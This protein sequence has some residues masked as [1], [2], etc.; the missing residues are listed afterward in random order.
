MAPFEAFDHV[1]CLTEQ[2]LV[3]DPALPNG[4]ATGYLVVPYTRD[5]CDAQR[6]ARGTNAVIA[7]DPVNPL[8][9]ANTAVLWEGLPPG[10]VAFPIGSG[11]VTHTGQLSE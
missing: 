6:R 3:A 11:H 7:E 8:A 10:A 1:W 2:G 4:M 5:F 9:G